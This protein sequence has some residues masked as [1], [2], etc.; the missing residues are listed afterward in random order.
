MLSLI[1]NGSVILIQLPSILDNR[2]NHSFLGLTN[3]AVFVFLQIL[4]LYAW[5]LS[6]RDK[7]LLIRNCELRILWKSSILMAIMIF[8]WMV[9]PYLVWKLSILGG[10]MDCLNQGAHTKIK[11]FSE[12][13]C[14][15]SCVC[16]VDKH[17]F[18]I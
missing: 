9:A 2:V 5:E 8:S 18:A 10:K 13:N 15:Y 4:K 11:F 7:V 1:L 3:K 14:H 16:S 17:I 12:L 6:F